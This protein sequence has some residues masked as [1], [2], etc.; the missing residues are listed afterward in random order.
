MEQENKLRQMIGMDFKDIDEA[1][2]FIEMRIVENMDIMDFPLEHTFTPGLYSR[3]IFMPADTLL[4]SKIH[5]T[6]HQ[7][8]ILK[9]AVMVFTE[10]KGWELYEAGYRG[11]TKPGTRRL[12]FNLVDT[13]WCT[14]HAT[15]KTTPE[16]VEED[17]IEK[18]DN[19]FIG[20]LK[21]QI[22]CH[23]LQS[24]QE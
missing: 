24:G 22:L 20:N 15:D 19:Q 14:Y 12:L 9:G 7:F 6:E 1:L 5:K 10:G 4:T 21:D 18:R 23:S 17:I 3:T 13:V 16:D 2:D 11:V 8:S